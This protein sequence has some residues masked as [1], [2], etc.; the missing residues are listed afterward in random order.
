MILL[1][2]TFQSTFQLLLEL[3][4]HNYSIPKKNY[5]NRQ[6]I[7]ILYQQH[8]IVEVEASSLI[9]VFREIQIKD[10]APKVQVLAGFNKVRQLLEQ[11]ENHLIKS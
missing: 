10:H 6:L 2:S 11:E 3:L 7:N 8:S 9:Q 5:Q 1:K 4:D